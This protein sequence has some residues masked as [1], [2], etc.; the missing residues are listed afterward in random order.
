MTA[1]PA[2]ACPACGHRGAHV[3]SVTGGL[4]HLRCDD[5]GSVFHADM[6]Q[7]SRHALDEP[8]DARRRVADARAAKLRRFGCRAV[9]EIECG[10]GLF[11]DAVR[12]LGLQGEG[13]AAAPDAAAVA[14][15]QVIHP[16][17]SEPEPR[18][19]AVALWDV[20]DHVH[21]PGDMLLQAR[22]WLRPGGFLALS[23]ASSGGLPAHALGPGL[24]GVDPTTAIFF[25]RRGLKLLLGATGYDP[26]RWISGSGLGREPL[27]HGL[28]RRWFG[29][30]WPGRALA[31]GLAIAAQLPLRVIDR[32]GLGSTFEVYAVAGRG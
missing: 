8:G 18:F 13:L 23:T 21:D 11:L 28:E 15:G 5:C 26:V 9:L 29:A 2:R 20:L 32:A 10:D 31:Q 7:A 6:N 14:R 24:A 1:S 19:D 4:E 16:L 3:A 30:S 17:A 25:S 27:R 22:R 12:D